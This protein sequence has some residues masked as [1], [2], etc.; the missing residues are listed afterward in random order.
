MG[1]NRIDLQSLQ[2]IDSVPISGTSPDLFNME[3]VR[4][5]LEG[6]LKRRR[7]K[8]DPD[9]LTY[10][11][12][13]RCLV[14]AGDERLVTP[15]GIL[16]F[17]N[18]PQRFFASSGVHLLHTFR[19]DSADQDVRANTRWRSRSN[20]ARPYMLRLISLSRFTCP[21]TCPLL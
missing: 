20:L 15:A 2:T 6:A 3:Q 17:A 4:S 10:L 12:E 9:P 11:I 18:E 8:G 13:R 5:H 21:S 1:E 7:Y 19:A 16:A 14:H